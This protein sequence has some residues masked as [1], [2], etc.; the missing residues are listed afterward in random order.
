M[1]TNISNLTTFELIAPFS[2]VH[3]IMISIFDSVKVSWPATQLC[4]QLRNYLIILIAIRRIFYS[5][6]KLQNAKVK[7]IHIRCRIAKFWLALTLGLSRLCKYF[8]KLSSRF[9]GWRGEANG[10]GSWK[11]NDWKRQYS[12][13]FN[14]KT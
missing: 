9:G 12:H 3:N 8:D 5:I 2:W 7:I 1:D 11:P 14:L 6:L 13:I 10:N 4:W